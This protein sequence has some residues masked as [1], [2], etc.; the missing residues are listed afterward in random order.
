MLLKSMLVQYLRKPELSV[1]LNG[2]NRCQIKL[3]S[4]R[5]KSKPHNSYLWIPYVKL[6]VE[7]MSFNYHNRPK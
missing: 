2:L 5:T 3:L 6:R 4:T 7:L 1:L